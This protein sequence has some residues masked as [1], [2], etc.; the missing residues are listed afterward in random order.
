MS[1]MTTT[2]IHAPSVNLDTT[3]TMSTMKVA[4]AAARA[5]TTTP[6]CH[7]FALPQVVPHHARLATA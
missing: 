5:L 7:G 6:S 2:G 4:T 3:T 1:G